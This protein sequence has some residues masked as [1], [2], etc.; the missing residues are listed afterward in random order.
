MTMYQCS[1]CNQ[2]FYS[3]VLTERHQAEQHPGQNGAVIALNFKC[4]VCGLEFG[5]PGSVRNHALLS[6][7]VHNVD[8]A[9]QPVG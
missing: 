3:P 4:P 8:V 2:T 7:G 6:H 5:H 1:L 9:A